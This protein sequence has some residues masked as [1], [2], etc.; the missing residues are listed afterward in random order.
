MGLEAEQALPGAA[1]GLDGAVMSEEGGV[2]TDAFTEGHCVWGFRGW[3][4]GW[5]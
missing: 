2:R 1:S 5:R 3:F 4:P